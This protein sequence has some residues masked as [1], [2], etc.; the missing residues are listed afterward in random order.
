MKIRLKIDTLGTDL[1]YELTNE[2]NNSYREFKIEVVGDMIPNN[3]KPHERQIFGFHQTI[4]L[5]L[6]FA[7]GVSSGIIANWL[8]E[9]LKGHVSKITIERTEIR[10]EK[11]EIER[12]IHE[13]IKKE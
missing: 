5:V 11:G 13:T 9:K 6:S 2:D 4:E 8:Y 10:L 7:T 1:M 3:F 12:V